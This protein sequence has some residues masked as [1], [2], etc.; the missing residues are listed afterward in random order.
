MKLSSMDMIITV[1]FII[2]YALIAFEHKLKVNKAALALLTGVM[3]WVLYILPSHDIHH[4]GEQLIEHLGEI[5]GILF[6]LMG[7]MT[8]VE[9][10][11]AHNGFDI[12]SRSINTTSKRKLLWIIGILT[13]F[14]SAV[15]DNLTTTIVMITLLRK[16]ISSKEE[17][18]MFAGMVVISAN[19]GGAWSPIGDVTTTMLWIG[20]QITSGNIILKVFVPSVVSMVVPLLFFTFRLKGTFGDQQTKDRSIDVVFEKEKKLFFYAGIGALL[21]VPVFKTVTHLPPFMGMLFGLGVLWVLSELVHKDKDESD[22][23][24]F[25]V[26]HA[27]RKIDMPS[28]L[29]FL[30]IL[31]AISALQSAGQLSMLAAFMNE[32]IGNINLVVISIG[33]LSA[34]VD[35]VPLVAAAM[36]M[37][38]LS[39]YPTDHYFWEFL[40][41]CAGTGGSALIIGSAAGVAAMGM[42][43]IEFFWYVKKITLYALIGYFAGALA[44]VAQ[45]YLLHL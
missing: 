23:D 36:G 18:L 11:D 44:Y 28:V 19:S 26:L 9:L 35:N 42:E 2:G 21:F 30:G 41:Y 5:S 10:I 43:K 33:L 27:L 24:K 14:L 16:L 40:A 38:D 12:I 31:V 29:F 8:I 25:S 3:C 17:R 20:G 1:V 4:V 32:K 34:V 37:Y 6:F 7:A 15:L 22:K 39:I 13:F 45:H